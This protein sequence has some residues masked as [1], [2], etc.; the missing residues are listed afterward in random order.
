MS[1]YLKHAPA[2]GRALV[3]MTGRE[4]P[5]V[6]ACSGSTR[7]APQKKTEAE[8][9]HREIARFA[10]RAVFRSSANLLE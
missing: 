2:A 1:L 10:S 7:E 4:H 6:P 9:R 5:G 8:L 3:L